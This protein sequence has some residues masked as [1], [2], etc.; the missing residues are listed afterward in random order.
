MSLFEA[1]G[2]KA[3]DVPFGAAQVM[4]ALMGGHIDAVVQLPAAVAANVAGGT[5]RVLAVLGAARD[6][7][8]PDAPTAAEAGVKMAP[9]DLWRGVAAPKGTPPAV[10]ARLAAAV[11]AAIE[12]PEFVSAGRKFGFVPAYLPAAEFGSLIARED[13][14][15]ARQMQALGLAKPR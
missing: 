1:A 9:M 2:V 15:L 6:P 10:I 5:L 11:Q 3:L 14:F 12:R 8:F 4:P 13:Q 7:L